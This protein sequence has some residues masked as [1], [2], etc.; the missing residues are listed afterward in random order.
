MS[1]KY[2]L[3]QYFAVSIKLIPLSTAS[4]IVVIDS[5]LFASPYAPDIPQHPSPMADTFKPDEP[6]VLIF[7]NKGLVNLG[8]H[9]VPDE[10]VREA[11]KWFDAGR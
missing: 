10:I 7:I 11:L 4:I 5:L 2:L 6:R 8:G 3:K 9:Y 1:I